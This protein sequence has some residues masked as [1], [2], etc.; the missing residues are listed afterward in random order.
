MPGV[1]QHNS[2]VCRE[3]D[4]YARCTADYR[5]IVGLTVY[6]YFLTYLVVFFIQIRGTQL[7]KVN[8]C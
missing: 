2:H 7:R 4:Y 3:N 5:P 8:T 1:L 6:V